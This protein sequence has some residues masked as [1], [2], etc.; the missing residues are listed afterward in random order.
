MESVA[1]GEGSNLS[2]LIGHRFISC[3]CY[4]LLWFRGLGSVSCNTVS[5]SLF[6]A[7]GQEGGR[8]REGMDRRTDTLSPA[9]LCAEDLLGA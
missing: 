2:G 5:N 1:T 7:S 6:P 4:R 8:E 3:S 9:V